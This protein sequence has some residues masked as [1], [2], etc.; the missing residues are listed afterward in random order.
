MCTNCN[1]QPESLSSQ[2][3]NIDLWKLWEVFLAH[4]LGLVFCALVWSFTEHSL[5]F[6]RNKP[7]FLYIFHQ[8]DDVGGG[9]TKMISDRVVKHHMNCGSSFYA[10]IIKILS[11]NQYQISKWIIDGVNFS[12]HL[13]ISKRFLR[14]VR[15]I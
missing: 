11:E 4:A 14:H 2:C 3:I 8:C 9:P 1:E 6:C 15:Y 5:Q 12:S 10:F 13:A 7:R